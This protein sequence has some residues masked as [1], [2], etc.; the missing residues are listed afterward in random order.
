MKKYLFLVSMVVTLLFGAEKV[1]ASTERENL[2]ESDI[3]QV[4]EY[5]ESNISAILENI[6]KAPKV[7]TFS[8]IKE[9]ETS[10]TSTEGVEYKLP[11]YEV[12]ISNLVEDIT[13]KEIIAQTSI[14]DTSE[15]NEDTISPLAPGSKYQ[16]KWDST[17]SV[18]A[19]TTNYYDVKYS[20][21]TEYKLTSVSGGY[22]ISQSGVQITSQALKYGC[23][24]I[25]NTQIGNKSPTSSSWSYNTGFTKY[26][27][28]ANGSYVMGN[29]VTL[30]IKRGSSWTLY[31]QNNVI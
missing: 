22:T 11:V 9:N 2:T 10:F 8:S 26:I 27:S 20:S 5:L 16:E 30:N 18:L 12:D 21:I 7:S 14:V 29:N 13:G 15:A 4:E 6:K 3:V 24:D 23:S 17:Y 28:P 25:F 1:N 31:L 19:W